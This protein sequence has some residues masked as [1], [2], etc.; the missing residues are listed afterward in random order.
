[1]R[2]QQGNIL[3][4]PAQ[5]RHFDTDDIE[6]KIQILAETFFRGLAA[7]IA[8]GGGQHAHVHGDGRIRTHPLHFALLQGA[9]QFGLKRQGHLA[10]FIQ[11]QRAAIGLHEAPLTPPVRAGKRAFF[12]AEEL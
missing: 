10:D 7:Q 11:K 12:V 6:P 9:Q 3:A 4:A 2:G 5:G 1:M 8:V